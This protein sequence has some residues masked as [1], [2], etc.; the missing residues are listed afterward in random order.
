MSNLQYALLSGFKAVTGWQQNI[1]RN[2]QG[3]L[4]PGYNRLNQHMSDQSGGQLSFNHVGTATGGSTSGLYGGGDSLHIGGTSLG[5]EQGELQPAYSPT[6][7]AV[8]GEGFFIV[9]ENLRPGARLFV[10]RNGDFR[11]DSQG[12]LVNSQGLFV[13]GGG[14]NLTDPPTP[15]LNPGDG[16]VV[17][18]SITLARIPVPANLGV[19]QYGTTT[20]ELTTQAGVMRPLPNGAA[21]VGFVQSSTLEFQNRIGAQAQLALE[22][23]QAQ[24][25]YKMIKDM[26]DSY[27]RSSDDAIGLIR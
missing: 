21:G 13:V 4:T 6:S 14:G 11:Y 12:R 20:Y 7:L 15:I 3:L 16:S 19:S 9:A 8:K 1:A 2:A 25:T 5:F 22:T 27:N 17:L 24:Q 26:L 10:T 23:N 18:P